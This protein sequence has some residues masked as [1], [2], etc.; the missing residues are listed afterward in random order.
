ME[1][2]G[3]LFITFFHILT[4]NLFM[5]NPSFLS[6]GNLIALCSFSK[7]LH[8]VLSGTQADCNKQVSL[9]PMLSVSLAK[10]RICLWAMHSFYG[11]SY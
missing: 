4:N 7:G 2:T 5:W 6:H 1:K 11:K 9:V 10:L 3:H 8:Q